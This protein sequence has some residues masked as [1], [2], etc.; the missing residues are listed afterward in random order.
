MEL[1]RIEL[2]YNTYGNNLHGSKEL[3]AYDLYYEINR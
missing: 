2:R 3:S 1:D